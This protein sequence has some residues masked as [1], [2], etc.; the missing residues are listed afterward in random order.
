MKQTRLAT[1]CY[2]YTQVETVERPIHSRQ[3]GAPVRQWQ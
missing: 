1:Y 2:S 3:C